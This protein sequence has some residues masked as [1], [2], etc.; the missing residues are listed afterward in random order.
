MDGRCGRCF[1]FMQKEKEKIFMST[2]M[3]S[4][5]S[6]NQKSKFRLS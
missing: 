1:E 3:Q 4:G 6:I 2:A 5:L